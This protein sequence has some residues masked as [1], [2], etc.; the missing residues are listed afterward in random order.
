MLPPGVTAFSASAVATEALLDKLA[1]LPSDDPDD[2]V[3]GA[4]DALVEYRGTL[5]ALAREVAAISG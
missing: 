2:G 3:G 1:E 5:A 4:V